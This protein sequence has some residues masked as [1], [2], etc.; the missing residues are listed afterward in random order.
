VICLRTMKSVKEELD[1]TSVCVWRDDVD[2]KEK[3]R[4][5]LTIRGRRA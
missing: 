2:V 3:S 1:K 5:S 4:S